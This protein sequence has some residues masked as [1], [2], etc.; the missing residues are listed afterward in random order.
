MT[1]TAAVAGAET[2]DVRMKK[3]CYEYELG[4]GGGLNLCGINILTTRY[5]YNSYSCTNLCETI[6]R[7]IV[8]IYI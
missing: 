3:T 7:V 5:Y 1:T 4:G 2:H 8:G 6:S